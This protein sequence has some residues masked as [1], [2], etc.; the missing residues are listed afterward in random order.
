MIFAEL[1]AGCNP[2]TLAFP[3]G[4]EEEFLRQY[5]AE[6]REFVRIASAVCFSVMAVCAFTDWLFTREI[7]YRLALIRFGFACPLIA[8]I[9]VLTFT[10][11]F[12]RVMQPAIAFFSVPV[13]FCVVAMTMVAPIQGRYL[14]YA[15]VCLVITC[16]H[17]FL[18][19]RFI[20]AI[21]GTIAI[22]L[23]YEFAAFFLHTP[24]FVLLG[25][26]I[27]LVGFNFIGGAVS[28]SA[29]LSTRREFVNAKL[30][31]AQNEEIKRQQ[32]L[33]ESLLLNIL[34]TEVAGELKCKGYVDPQYHEDVTILFTDFK[35]FT[36]STEE[37]AADDLVRKLNDYFTAF[38]EITGRYGLEKLKT[39]GDS[40]MCVC[41]LPTHVS[42]HAVDALLA[43]FEMVHEVKKRQAG[44]GPPWSIRIGLHTGPVIS[45]VVG[46]RKF[47]FD[48]WGES[49]NF[50]SRM[51]S[52]GSPDRINISAITYSKVKDFFWCES[53]G[54]VLTKEGRAYDMY[55]AQGLQPSLY[56]SEQGT[57]EDLFR[58]RYRKYFHREL[59][60]FPAT[61]TEVQLK[62]PDDAPTPAAKPTTIVAAADAGYL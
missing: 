53:R 27:F 4:E 46:I 13:G 55:F 25:D 10:R 49:V 44:D 29:E 24:L 31:A 61:L 6:S 30:V 1:P 17:T 45:G 9:F 51:E 40:Y 43:A 52:S 48:V 19:M 26:T 11:F 8:A 50:A 54:K 60:A 35:S 23:G 39:I 18:K 28:Y 32:E 36:L 21:T 58:K 15:G 47:A 41:G 42:S 37:L 7:T 2:L 14:Y 56:R 34:P 62:P 57:P 3:R 16:M 38:D 20:Y 12:P 59:D 22:S 33:A 5:T